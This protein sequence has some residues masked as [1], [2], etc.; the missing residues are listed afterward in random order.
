MAID[1]IHISTDILLRRIISMHLEG[2]YVYLMLLSYLM[3]KLTMEKLMFD[4]VA[5]LSETSM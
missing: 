5:E 2:K 3:L 4:C 1:K